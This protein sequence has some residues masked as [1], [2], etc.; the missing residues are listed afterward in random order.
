[1][2]ALTSAPPS[3]QLP[4][5]LGGV[6]LRLKKD[7]RRREELHVNKRYIF[8][9][10]GWNLWELNTLSI[11][12][13]GCEWQQKPQDFGWWRWEGASFNFAKGKCFID[14]P[15]IKQK[16]R[17]SLPHKKKYQQNWRIK[18][19]FTGRT[20]LQELNVGGLNRVLC[21]TDATRSDWGGRTFSDLHS[22]KKCGGYTVALCL[23]LSFYPRC[24]A[25]WIEVTLKSP[26]NCFCILLSSC[27]RGFAGNVMHHWFG[28]VLKGCLGKKY[29]LFRF[30][31]PP[32]TKA[33]LGSQSKYKPPQDHDGCW[34]K[35]NIFIMSKWQEKFSPIAFCHKTFGK[36]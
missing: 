22:Q 14:L 3:Q 25:K 13:K 5:E 12:Q 34:L 16:T 11:I 29:P 10:K 28:A 23:N 17:K 8:R 7:P 31:Y 21:S 32:T 35:I 30:S 4:L 1:M 24:F 26:M 19:T 2:I 36:L 20:K 18:A 15:S 27:S 6:R 33:K 9:K